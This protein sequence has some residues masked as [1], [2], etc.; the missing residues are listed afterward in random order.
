MEKFRIYSDLF[1]TR[2]RSNKNIL[3]RVKLRRREIEKYLSNQRHASLFGASSRIVAMMADRV[4]VKRKVKIKKKLNVKIPS[5]F[6]IIDN[7]IESIRFI[8]EFASSVKVNGAK[9]KQIHFDHSGMDKC[10]LAANSVLDVIAVEVDAERK[11]RNARNIN[12]SG[13][14]PKDPALARLIKGVGIIKHL[15]VK[16]AALDPKDA[17]SLEVFDVRNKNYEIASSSTLDKKSRTSAAF[18]DHV[19]KCLRRV[20]R[21]LS[22]IGKRNLSDYVGEVISNAE[23]HSEFKDW[24]IQGYL[25]DSLTVPMCE[26]AIFNFG[27]S[28]SESL[29]SVDRSGYS[30]KTH[31]QPYLDIHE[32]SSFFGSSWRREDLL[33]VVA[34][35]ANV[36]SK[37]TVANST[38][39]Q[40][41]VDLINFFQ[42]VHKECNVKSSDDHDARMA[43]VSGGTYIL[44]DGKYQMRKMDSNS[45]MILAFNEENSLKKKPDD[46]YVKPLGDW[47]F[48][49]TIISIRFPLSLT[50]GS[51]LEEVEN[52]RAENGH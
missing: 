18:V 33:T 42:K 29:L 3:R 45:G 27:K 7:P 35:Q 17:K 1:Y 50:A 44:F 4:E 11:K 13:I 47:H 12:P 46:R 40:G 41:T 26:I 22:E 36:S 6:S 25:D 28:I 48:P 24:T 37:N 34:M 5:V 31:I 38:R 8:L 49:G 20:K 15:D 14:L 19:N 16:N 52:G 21:E 23:D 43:I 30:W 2:K 51:L 9:F 39:G 32:K 10:D